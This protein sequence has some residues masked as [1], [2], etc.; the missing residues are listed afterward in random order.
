[1]Q[2]LGHMST[3]PHIQIIEHLDTLST[4]LG[5]FGL[6]NL[7]TRLIL[8]GMLTGGLALTM[9]V[10]LPQSS[11]KGIC[12]IRVG[13]IEQGPMFY[14]CTVCDA[15]VRQSSCSKHMQ[16]WLILI[17]PHLSP[18]GVTVLLQ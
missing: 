10:Q 13:S 12:Q 3:C 5:M 15:V 4:L 14:R 7:F 17:H 1:M 18:G 2:V 16:L 6:C 11:S 8:G 9:L